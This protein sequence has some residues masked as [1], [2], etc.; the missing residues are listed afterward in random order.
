M[1]RKPLL[2]LVSMAMV[3]ACGAVANSSSSENPSSVID[4]SSIES[5][6]PSSDNSLIDSSV[7]YSSEKSVTYDPTPSTKDH[8]IDEIYDMV[9][10]LSLT[11]TFNQKIYGSEDIFNFT[12]HGDDYIA[13]EGGEFD[14]SAVALK[15]YKKDSTG[16]LVY[17]CP[18]EK[19]DDGSKSYRIGEAIYYY[20]QATFEPAGPETELLPYSPT[21]LYKEYKT[22]Y[23]EILETSEKGVY[24]MNYKTMW[25]L[26]GTGGRTFYAYISN[27]INGAEYFGAGRLRKIKMFFNSEDH[28]VIVGQINS[29]EDDDLHDMFVSEFWDAGTAKD[30]DIE[31]F[32]KSDAAKISDE[33]MPEAKGNNIVGESLSTTTSIYAC[34]DGKEEKLGET[35]LD[36]TSERARMYGPNGTYYY[37]QEDGNIV[38]DYIDGWNMIS[39]RNTGVSW[40]EINGLKDEIDFDDFRKVGENK[41][42]YYG[43][44][45]NEIYGDIAETNIPD[46]FGITDLYIVTNSTGTAQVIA[47]SRKYDVILNAT[48][49]ETR[50]SYKLVT[51][52]VPNR[53]IP[54]VKPFETYKE[55][56]NFRAAFEVL[57]NKSIEFKTHGYEYDIDSGDDNP[58]ERYVT[59]AKD[60]VFDEFTYFKPHGDAHGNYTTI[61]IEEKT[62][63]YLKSE[64]GNITGGVDFKINREGK[65][66]AKRALNES[67]KSLSSMW[68]NSSMAPECFTFD[69]AT[70]TFTTRPQL[71]YYTALYTPKAFKNAGGTFIDCVRVTLNAKLDRVEKIEYDN[72]IL[73]DGE[74]LGT[75]VGVIDFTYDIDTTKMRSDLQAMAPFTTPTKWSDSENGDDIILEFNDYYKGLKDCNGQPFDM[76]DIPYIYDTTADYYWAPLQLSAFGEFWLINDAGSADP[77]YMNKILA[78]FKADPDFTFI[79]IG[80]YGES[81]FENGDMTVRVFPKTIDGIWFSKTEK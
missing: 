18:W 43:Y 76:D 64:G 1:K 26:Q 24:E 28:L 75:S 62:G 54:E 39:H 71:G 20:D 7:I 81:Y 35:E 60:F 52:I 5:S 49:K 45:F 55:C 53:T 65:V 63:T 34:Y 74:D 50:L 21:Y 48:G 47:E 79:K 10:K 29:F 3:T 8:S 4:S 13:Q 59:Y 69:A 33:A 46:G 44:N 68:W 72:H 40:S 6:L 56:E 70:R 30:A 38:E 58:S 42:R 15:N 41:Y 31:N 51:D 73:I 27:L 36:Y 11:N 14:Y 25:Y 2:L 12:Y 77:S 16:N 32:L 78:M 57:N 80:E 9:E 67:V 23:N 19:N 37:H 17:L 22:L 61:K 66:Q